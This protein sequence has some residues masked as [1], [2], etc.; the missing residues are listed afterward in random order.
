MK[1][2]NFKYK[3]CISSEKIWDKQLFKGHSLENQYSY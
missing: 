3:I 1:K 2:C